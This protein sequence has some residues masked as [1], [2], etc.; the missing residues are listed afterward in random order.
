M[1][2]AGSEDERIAGTAGA[3]VGT[4]GA[5]DVAA[6]CSAC[7]RPIVAAARLASKAGRRSGGTAAVT[8][9]SQLGLVFSR[10][11]D[12]CCT[13]PAA[14]I[15]CAEALGS[16]IVRSA[17]I[18]WA[19]SVRLSPLGRVVVG[20]EI[21]GVGPVVTWPADAVPTAAPALDVGP[22]DRSPPL[23]AAAM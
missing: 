4:G 1:V 15:A 23:H 7:R 18:S 12:R 9:A 17:A 11:Y 8:S 20:A 3:V 14:A 16:R 19:A 10:R 21:A 13:W 5:V 6:A 22:T 2:H